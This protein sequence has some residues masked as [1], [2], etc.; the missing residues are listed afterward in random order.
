MIRACG[1][2]LVASEGP[3]SERDWFRVAE[4]SNTRLSS[5]VTSVPMAHRWHKKMP[6]DGHQRGTLR[7][8]NPR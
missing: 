8:D 6:S 4:G 2:T 7:S 1:R 5:C 3:G